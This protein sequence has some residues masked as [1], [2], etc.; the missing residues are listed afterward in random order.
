MTHLLI[1]TFPDRDSA[2]EVGRKL[3]EESLIA[4]INIS[5]P[6][7]SIYKW[8]GAIK[9]E[10]EEGVALIKTEK[11]EEKVRERLEELHPYDVPEVLSLTA[12]ANADYERW[13][14]RVMDQ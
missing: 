5:Q 14:A 9:E 6:V 3:L 10:E 2:S 8:E 1:S 13:L 11:N 7:T 4:C 12:E